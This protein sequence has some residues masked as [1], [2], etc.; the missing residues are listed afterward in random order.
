MAGD[1][2]QL[3]SGVVSGSGPVLT[4]DQ[5]QAAGITVVTDENASLPDAGIV[6]TDIQAQRMITEVAI[7]GGISGAALDR[8]TPVDAGTPPLSYLLVAWMS[9]FGSP[10]AVLAASL[11]APG[12]IDSVATDSTANILFPDAVSALFAADMAQVVADVAAQDSSDVPSGSADPPGG[13]VLGLGALVSG[14]ASTGGVVLDVSYRVG[15]QAAGVVNGSRVLTN[16]GSGVCSAAQNFL[17]NVLNTAFNALKLNVPDVSGF[18]SLVAH[19][20]ATMWNRA[21]DLAKAFVT[22]LIVQIT[23]PITRVLQLAVYAGAIV[24]AIHSYLTGIKLHI[25]FDPNVGSGNADLRRGIVGVSVNG[26]DRG[27]LVATAPPLSATWPPFI[28]DCIN[29]VGA[30]IP[31]LMAVGAKA[32]WHTPSSLGGSYSGG[33][34]YRMID[35]PTAPDPI[36]GDTYVTY[37]TVVGGASQKGGSNATYL[38]F[39]TGDQEP[40]EWQTTCQGDPA[41]VQTYGGISVTVDVQQKAVNDLL[42]TLQQNIVATA[43][44]AMVG[45]APGIIKSG[46]RAAA[47]YVMDAITTEI[48]QEVA[49]I[50]NGAFDMHGWT[51]LTIKYHNPRDPSPTPPPTNT[52]DPR[53][54]AQHRAPGGVSPPCHPKAPTRKPSVGEA[55]PSGGY[56]P[57][58]GV[59]LSFISSLTRPEVPGDLVGAWDSR[60]K[61][62]AAWD[63][64]LQ[65]PP[66]Y[67]GQYPDDVQAQY[68]APYVDDGKLRLQV[69]TAAVA[70]LQGALSDCTYSGSDRVLV[71]SILEVQQQRAAYLPDSIAQYERERDHQ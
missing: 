7:G 18:W 8:M 6:V 30:T 19:V 70:V 37:T 20:V 35:T 28:V 22:D 46:I 3:V 31:D 44:D 48:R 58:L 23:G 33:P 41:E 57:P 25:D 10:D 43:V 24:S 66:D 50:L 40:A 47:N 71:N 68:S 27:R 63:A 32:V 62:E 52:A 2:G 26:P 60:V 17:A 34:V 16:G 51:I 42:D 67:A 59:D 12:A 65:N 14:T 4:V 49:G 13:G 9:T 38:D 36:F 54:N 56:F 64:F 29:A 53:P 21:V 1:A 69:V 45:L 61:A 55:D 11:M 5:L 15:T 39:D